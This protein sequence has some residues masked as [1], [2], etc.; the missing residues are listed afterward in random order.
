MQRWLSIIVV[1]G[2]GCTPAPVYLPGPVVLEAGLDVGAGTLSEARASLQIPVVL[3]SDDDRREREQLQREVDPSLVVPYVRSGDLEISVEWRVQNL[4]DQPGDA[5]IH[6][7]GANQFFSYE[8]ALVILSNDEDDPP[9]PP[10][11]GDIPIAVGPRSEVRGEFREDELR[12]AAI[13]LDQITRANVNPF[14]A[15][16]TPDR[17][18]AGIDILT[19]LTYDAQGE[20]QPQTATG[21]SIPAAAIAQL[22][23]I[24]LVFRPNR[25]M[26]MWFSVRVRDLRGD[27]LHELA[28]DAFADPTAMAELE[29]LIPQSFTP[30]AP[31]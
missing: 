29:P 11:L 18:K 3:E 7:N 8:P 16:L 10:L 28:G 27:L 20:P 5:R 22:L 12:E 6:L 19:A 30:A 17:H 26:K 2:S 23:R 4:T 13:D 24:D 21:V 9:A 25:Q 31:P 15:T 1:V 14:R